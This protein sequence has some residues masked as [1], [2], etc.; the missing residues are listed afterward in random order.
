MHDWGS[1]PGVTMC[2][3]RQPPRGP[4]L[5]VALGSSS[6]TTLDLNKPSPPPPPRP[7]HSS[8]YWSHSLVSGDTRLRNPF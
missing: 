2:S 4:D 6:F 1:Q 7:A 8:P 5:T 3:W